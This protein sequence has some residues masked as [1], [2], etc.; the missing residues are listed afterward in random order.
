MNLLWYLD[1]I[2]SSHFCSLIDTAKKMKTQATDSEKI[3]ANHILDQAHVSG[4]YKE[5]SKLNNKK[6]KLPPYKIGDRFKQTLYQKRYI[7]GK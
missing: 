1:L 2:R 4:R 6:N 7:F 3:F 5:L